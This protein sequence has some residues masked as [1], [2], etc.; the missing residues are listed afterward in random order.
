MQVFDNITSLTNGLD[1]NT[2]KDWSKMN[3]WF[4][5]LRG[6]GISTI[7]VHHTG[8]DGK[9]QRGTSS[10][11]ANIDN[12]WFIKKPK[13]WS[14]TDEDY[15]IELSFGN[16]IRGKRNG[17]F[18]KREI[19]F[20]NSEWVTKKINYSEKDGV[21]MDNIFY[22]AMKMMIRNPSARQIDVQSALN[23]HTNFMLFKKLE[24]EGYIN[25]PS[26]KKFEITEQGKLWVE[27]I[28]KTRCYEIDKEIGD[29]F[30]EALGENGENHMAGAM[31]TAIN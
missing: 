25:R 15:R 14:E 26:N 11:I 16:K 10:R 7:I 19:C 1:E 4:L 23:L 3:Q 30:H 22:R 27:Y 21:D 13:D 2:T 28:Q 18:A 9:S 20:S 17:A 31:E 24:N 5:K 6:L 8:K 29:Y 12:E